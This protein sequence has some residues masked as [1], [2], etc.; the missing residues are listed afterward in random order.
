MS[1][2]PKVKAEHQKLVGLLQ[3]M[4]VPTWMWEDIIMDFVVGL[5]QPQRKNDSIWVV[6]D[7]LTK[8][9][10]FIHF[11]STYLVKEYAI[12]YKIEIKSLHGSLYPSFWREV[13]NS[14]FDYGGL[15][16]KG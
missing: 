3:D 13:L 8:S 4:Q 10:H 12:I 6:V 14:L 1:K 5:P 15:S 16:K 2:L 9:S 7:K 11:K